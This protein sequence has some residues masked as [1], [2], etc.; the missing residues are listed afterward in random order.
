MMNHNIKNQMERSVFFD[1]ILTLPKF[2]RKKD[3]SPKN[4]FPPRM[5]AQNERK[6]Y[7]K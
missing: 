2:H 6:K 5:V 4:L 1:E 7:E 3:F